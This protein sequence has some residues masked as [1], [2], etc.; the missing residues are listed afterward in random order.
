[1]Y[2]EAA[3]QPTAVGLEEEKEWGSSVG[4]VFT[5]SRSA[6][7]RKKSTSWKPKLITTT[8]GEE[9]AN[10][11]AVYHLKEKFSQMYVLT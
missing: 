6:E 7:A 9:G 5:T 10:L 8:E 11:T 4:F 2:L 1:M 3:L